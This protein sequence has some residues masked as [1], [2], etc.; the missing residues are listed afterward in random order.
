MTTKNLGGRP[1]VTLNTEQQAQVE[2]LAAFLPVTQIADYFGFKK[3]TFYEILK[4]QPEV[5]ERYKKG[6]AQAIAGAANCLL[7]NVQKGNVLAQMF[8]L[9]T[10]AGWRETGD[11]IEEYIPCLTDDDQSL[12]TV[13]KELDRVA[14]RAYGITKQKS[15]SG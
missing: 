7:K 5:S 10:R 9:K 13:V 3:T 15:G 12:E 8:Y 11:V 1:L 6:K 14:E 2:A 4:R